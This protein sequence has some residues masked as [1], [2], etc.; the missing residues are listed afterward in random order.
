MKALVSMMIVLIVT[1]CAVATNPVAMVPEGYVAEKIQPYSVKI[2]VS[3]GEETSSLGRSNISDPALKE[4]IETAISKT[5]AFKQLIKMGD[6]DFELSAS[7]VTVNQPIMGGSFTVKTDLAWVLTKQQGNKVVWRKLIRSEH[8][9]SVGEAFAGAVR[10]RLA[11]EGAVR[12]N[13]E[14]ALK[15]IAGL[16]L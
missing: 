12:N 7:I 10:L 4:A 15:E 16:N 11:T 8:T 6:A 3:G 9:I 1:G 13:I 14:K 2:H 5:R